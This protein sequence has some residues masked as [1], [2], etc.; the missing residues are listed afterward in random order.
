MKLRRLKSRRFL[1]N[2][3]TIPFLLL[4]F[5]TMI[6]F[7]LII[8]SSTSTQSQ[9]IRSRAFD[10]VREVPNGQI[11][12]PTG[13]IIVTPNPNATATPIP[14]PV[15][16]ILI[17]GVVGGSSGPLVTG[18]P[19]PT[20]SVSPSPR[21]VPCSPARVYMGIPCATPTPEIYLAP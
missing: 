17:T 21:L 9:D 2:P 18:T 10:D 11:P 7:A 5:V 13:L 4:L 1:R 12:R 19:K 20:S 14:G 16:G 3:W 8:Q 6:S 15:S